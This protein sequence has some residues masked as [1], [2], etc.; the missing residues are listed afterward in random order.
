VEVQTHG[1]TLHA[2]QNDAMRFVGG[3]TKKEKA[4]A[5]CPLEWATTKFGLWK[6]LSHWTLGKF[7]FLKIAYK[8]GNVIITN[9]SQLTLTLSI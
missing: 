3:P 2:W 9:S 7:N 6:I 4:L 1:G 8:S 5:F